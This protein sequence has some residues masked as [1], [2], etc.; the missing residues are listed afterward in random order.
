MFSLGLLVLAVILQRFTPTFGYLLL[1]IGVILF[2]TAYLTSFIKPGVG[3]RDKRWRGRVVETRPVP[4][5]EKL[6]YWLYRR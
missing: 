2:L 6:H 3:L 4:W 5:W 1:W